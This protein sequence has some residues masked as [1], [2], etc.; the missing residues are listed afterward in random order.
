MAHSWRAVEGDAGVSA[1]V[2]LVIDDLKRLYRG[3]AVHATAAEEHEAALSLLLLMM[4]SDRKL[5]LDEQDEIEAFIADSDWAS[6]TFDIGSRFGNAMARARNAV[7]SAAG[8]DALLDEVDETIASRI[9]RS[10]LYAACK[11]VA[12]ADHETAPEEASLLA[13]IEALFGHPGSPSSAAG[14]VDIGDQVD[15]TEEAENDAEVLP[16]AESA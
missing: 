3:V 5:R 2:A 10:E 16:A 8:I 7:Q 1:T 6:D 11:S 9:L 14:V 4:I 12:E 15:G 13:K